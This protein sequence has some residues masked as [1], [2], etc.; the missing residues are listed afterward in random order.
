MKFKHLDYMHLLNN[1]RRGNYVVPFSSHPDLIGAV[2]SRIEFWL[3]MYMFITTGIE[4]SPSV[5]SLVLKRCE[6]IL[7][8]VSK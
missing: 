7:A 1:Q 5:L 2:C 6:S 4:G 8:A 3:L